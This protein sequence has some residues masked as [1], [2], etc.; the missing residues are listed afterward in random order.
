MSTT[1][2]PYAIIK[3]A[4]KQFRVVQ[5]DEFITDRLEAGEGKTVTTDQV[6]LVN[7]GKKTVI[8]QPLVEK[9][10]VKY[11]I[12]ENFRSKKLRVA[13]YKAKSRYRRVK[14]HRQH[15]SKVEIVSI[16]TG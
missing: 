9:A 13:K 11:K 6:L 14:G 4:G 8:G 7:D 1:N 3:L 10:Q 15:Q 2:Q 16:K 5:G 12:T